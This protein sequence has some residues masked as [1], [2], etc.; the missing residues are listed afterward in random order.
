[1]PLVLLELH[2]VA[3]A[4]PS[5]GHAATRIATHMNKDHAES[6]SWY[7]QVLGRI[8][9][10]QAKQNPKIVSFRSEAMDIE[11][12]KE[13]R[14]KTFSHQWEPRM[15]PGQARVRLEELHTVTRDALGLSPWTL[16]RFRLPTSTLL[17]AAALLT[18]ELWLAFLLPSFRAAELFGW[19][20]PVFNPVLSFFHIRPTKEN[21]GAAVRAW[22]LGVIVASHT[23]EIPACLWPTLR[24]FNCESWGLWTVYSVLTFVTGFP[25]W[26]ALRKIGGKEEAKLKKQ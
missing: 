2:S 4:P 16:D 14:R 25:V 19:H 5:A 15:E 18:L 13:G 24:R 22:W 10:S 6:L 11:Y 3:S 23:Y 12:G 20:A 21:L 8:P 26:T 1:M 17:T 7:L 9:K